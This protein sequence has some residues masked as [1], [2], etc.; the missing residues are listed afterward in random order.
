MFISLVASRWYA[1]AGFERM[2]TRRI[3][4]T[5]SLSSSSCLATI[6]RPAL[7]DIPVTFPPGRARLAMSPVP[8]GS[9]TV[10]MTMGI[11]SVAFLAAVTQAPFSPGCSSKRQ[12]CSSKGAYNRPSYPGHYFTY[13]G[14]LLRQGAVD[15]AKADDQRHAG[16]R[17]HH[18]LQVRKAVGGKIVYNTL[19]KDIPVISRSEPAQGSAVGA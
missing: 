12:W 19:P 18:H 3:A 7:P 15:K 9:R 10:I 13:R 14:G 4:G 6:S 2:A 5:V 16:E 8:T 17:Q 1:L 11:V